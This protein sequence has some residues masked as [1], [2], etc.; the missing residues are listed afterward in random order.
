MARYD[1]ICSA[2]AWN[3]LVSDLKELGPNPPEGEVIE[4]LCQ[5]LWDTE[6]ILLVDDHRE[7]IR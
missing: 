2:E 3:R 1:T 6:D 5:I 7:A 4:V